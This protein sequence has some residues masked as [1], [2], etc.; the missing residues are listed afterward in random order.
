RQG[1]PR[2]VL[3][4][5]RRVRQDVHLVEEALERRR[6]VGPAAAGKDAGLKAVGALVMNDRH[7]IRPHPPHPPREQ[8]R[9]EAG[10]QGRN[11]WPVEPAAAVAARLRAHG[12]TRSRATKWSESSTS[13]A[14]ADG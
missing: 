9:G 14:S 10:Q 8:R 7:G 11:P 6:G 4:G 3:G 13:H 2:L 1:V 5:A 12:W